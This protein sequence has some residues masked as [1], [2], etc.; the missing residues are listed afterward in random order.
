MRSASAE[1]MPAAAVFSGDC[2]AIA[3]V[4]L[5]KLLRDPTEL[6]TRAVQP[7]LWLI[8][9]GQ[10]LRAACAASPPAS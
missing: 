6:V 10:V 2:V 8:V 3:D 9:F 7:V 5:R 1:A 4:E